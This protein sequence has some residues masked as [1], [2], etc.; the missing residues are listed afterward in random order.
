MIVVATNKKFWR[1]ADVFIVSGNVFPQKT[2]EEKTKEE[3]SN[4]HNDR[5]C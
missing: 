2:K 4:K 3:T 1:Q 5:L